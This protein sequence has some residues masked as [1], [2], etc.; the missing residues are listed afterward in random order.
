MTGSLT[1]KEKSATDCSKPPQGWRCTRG[2]GH[3]GPCAA[4]PTT[5]LEWISYALNDA[6]T[7]LPVLFTMLA[8]IGARE[9]AM[10]AD[11]ILG[12]VKTAQKQCAHLLEAQ[13]RAAH[14]PAGEYG[15]LMRPK[16][17]TEAQDRIARLVHEV[18]AI[19]DEFGYD[20][21]EWIATDE[22]GTTQ[23]PPVDEA[24]LRELAAHPNAQF[25]VAVCGPND[26]TIRQAIERRLGA[27]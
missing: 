24:F 21:T 12:H 16:G 15:Y 19:C 23:P 11:E 13:H 9:G 4:L 10:V 3:G 8:K 20:P 2:A 5:E 6:A 17:H 25:N 22:D 18:E 7:A 1:S 26:L 14:E 27:P